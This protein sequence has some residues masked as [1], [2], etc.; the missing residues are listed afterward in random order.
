MLTGRPEQQGQVP[1]AIFSA[2][3]KSGGSARRWAVERMAG[4]QPALNVM[5]SLDAL[6]NSGDPPEG[7]LWVRLGEAQLGKAGLL[8]RIAQAVKLAN[9]LDAVGARSVEAASEED[10]QVSRIATWMLRSRWKATLVRTLLGIIS[11][12]RAK[13][14]R[15]EQKD[16]NGDLQALLRDA[17]IQSGAGE[18]DLFGRFAAGKDAAKFFLAAGQYAGIN[19]HPLF[20]TR[21][22]ANRFLGESGGSATWHHFATVG[23]RTC[24]QPNPY[25]FPKWY[26]EKANQV[27]HANSLLD[28]IAAMRMRR[29]FPGPNVFFDES[30]Y[31]RNASP[32]LKEGEMPLLHFLQH[33]AKQPTCEYFARHPASVQVFIEE[34]VVGS[35]PSPALSAVTLEDALGG[36]ERIAVCCVLTGEYDATKPI[37][38]VERNVDYFL[39]TDVPPSGNSMHWQT[40]VL[41]PSDLSPLLRSREAK[42]QLHRF[43]PEVD[44]YAAVVYVDANVELVGGVGS[45]IR[46]F[47]DG[48]TDLGFVKHPLRQCVFEEAAAIVLKDKD[49][50]ENVMRTVAFLEK[51]GHPDNAGLFEMNLF[52]FRPGRNAEAFMDRWW[53][54]YR[55]LGKRDQLLVPAVI[56]EQSL[57][58]FFL[59]PFGQ[60]VRNHPSFVYHSHLEQCA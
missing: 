51:Q 5:V 4:Q 42:M 48:D 39:I 20:W 23:Q 54:L 31:A 25:F 8:G 45:L 29:S 33:G 7:V 3:L 13:R 46:P 43:L 55:E 6:A 30:W 10:V 57:Q 19:P 49:T 18:S 17:A 2:S 41:P 44:S 40:I 28:L 53:S 35:G 16:W 58:P 37:H 50:F 32:A 9:C 27:L 1:L 56:R 52:C 12:W 47:L 14:F 34:P 59:M 22:Y 24:L 36:D 11:P 38:Y 21:W 15:A 60:S 26:A